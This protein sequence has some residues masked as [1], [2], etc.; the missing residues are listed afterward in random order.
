MSKTEIEG[1][2]FYELYARYVGEPESKK[3]VY[4]YWLFLF[5]SLIGFLGI[6]IFLIGTQTGVSEFIDINIISSAAYVTA[7]SGLPLALLGIVL[8]LPVQRWGIALSVIGTLV[9]LG[10]VAWFTQ[11]FPQNWPPITQEGVENLAPQVVAVYSVGVG[12][13][14]LVTILV[15]V[16]T[17]EKSIFFTKEYERSQEYP[18]VAV[19]DALR[20]GMF[21]VYRDEDDWQWRLIDQEAIATNPG[22]FLSRLETEETVDS[23]REKVKEAGLLEIKHAAFRLYETGEDTWRWVLMSEDGETI[24]NSA[25]DFES[26]NA[27]ANAVNNLKELGPDAEVINIEGGGAFEYVESG[28][29]VRW[30]L[31]D[32]DREVLAAGPTGYDNRERAETGM[33]TARA[34][35]ADAR[36]LSI[37][38]I[39]VELFEDEDGLWQ[40]RLVDAEDTELARS[41][42]AFDSRRNAEEA[43]YDLLEDVAAAPIVDS[44]R[45][46]FET[47]PTANG[48]DWRLVDGE[49]AVVA[50]SHDDHGSADAA[51]RNAA[52][53]RDE[54]AEAD[55]VSIDDAEFE[56]FQGPEGWQWRL[57]TASRDV[58]AQ[59][60]EGYPG[61]SD[62]ADAIEEIR[63]MA[64]DAE[65][66]EFEQ[67]AF[68]L[69]EHEGEWRWRLID[70]DGNVMADSGEQH[71]DRDSAAAS[72]MTIKEQAPDAEIL[73]IENAAF[74]L[75]H[76][77]DDRW[78]WR[79]VDISGE[80]VAHGPE[81]LPSRSDAREAMDRLV[82]AATESDVRP[83]EGAVFQ[84]YADR[85]DQWRWWFVR[86]DGT[87]VADGEETYATRDEA[88][89]AI[90]SDVRSVADGAEVYAIERLA[91]QVDARGDRYS[92]RVID[93]Q[94]ETVAASSRSYPDREQVDREVRLFQDNAADATVFELTDPAFQIRR[95]DEG[96]DWRLVGADRDPLLLSDAPHGSR[97]DAEAEIETV[98]S[99][100]GDA[101][102]LDYEGAAFEILETEDSRWT[103][104]LVDDVG[105]VMAASAQ[106]YGTESEAEDALDRVREELEDASILEIEIAA[107][108]LQEETGQ[109]TWRLI[110]ETGN[111]IAESVIRYD[112]RR[113]ARESMEA[114]Q[115]YAPTAQTQV[116]E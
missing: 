43:V 98:K 86:A 21:S 96:W 77:D 95:G 36:T 15:P 35:A 79:L 102:V 78:N 1:G 39:G 14:A 113:E 32:E 104:Q 20:G 66:I 116:A 49:E 29:E 61:R 94:R 112:S 62:A 18:D 90:E 68:Q 111:P 106:N 34:A 40:W 91:L 41:E 13:V 63:G 115:E 52:A 72:M 84:V 76:D 85:D 55:V 17:G 30:R 82:D 33:E 27:A 83:M 101:G 92:W 67:S 2:R 99:I 93:S 45:A 12:I 57:V 4:G 19:G 88:V 70:E 46:G 6:G 114:L 59:S 109:W 31:V 107:F 47:V 75:F 26:R 56:Y 58:L 22:S 80:E 65:L 7:A 50:R 28:G 23:I 60:T 5:G 108:E 71:E 44:A 16:F 10:A 53:M 51:Q 89:T 73:E 87:I 110:D 38:T 69:Y 81:M 100:I 8:L 24:S 105:E 54:A 74:E 103:W 25:D 48:W 64:G 97:A 3:D 37:E 11:V 42:G 9:A